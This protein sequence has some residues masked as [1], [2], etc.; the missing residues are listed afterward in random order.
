MYLT[1]FV[2]HVQL[3][4][5]IF[6]ERAKQA[7]QKH[8]KQLAEKEAEE[9]KRQE[10]KRRKEEQT[11]KE[12]SAI[13]ELT[14]EEAERMQREIDEQKYVTT[15][16][17]HFTFY[18][19]F[20]ICDLEATFFLNWSIR[21]C[22]TKMSNFNWSFCLGI[23]N[24]RDKKAAAQPV[25]EKEI[26]KPLGDEAD[27]EGEESEKSKLKPNEGNGCNLEHYK[28]TQTLAE[29]EVSVNFPFM[30]WMYSHLWWW[31]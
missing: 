15:P 16:R 22:D 21:E 20:V 28:W 13:Y 25:P 8:K 12:S 5:G 11:K 4:L 7:Q 1:V 31:F 10:A 9:K 24:C 3:L 6:Q 2:L 19:L 18:I 30:T 17:T 29:V 23:S 26:S 14:D 27:K